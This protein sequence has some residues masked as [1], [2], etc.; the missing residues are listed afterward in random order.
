LVP[1]RQALG[2]S[3]NERPRSKHQRP[4]DLQLECV[5]NIDLHILEPELRDDFINKMETNVLM[6][7][8]FENDTNEYDKIHRSEIRKPDVAHDVP[9]YLK[10][11]PDDAH[12]SKAEEAF[13]LSHE[14]WRNRVQT[15]RLIRG[16]LDNNPLPWGYFGYRLPALDMFFPF[17]FLTRR[18]RLT[19]S[20]DSKEEKRYQPLE[21]DTFCSPA[22]KCYSDGYTKII[23]TF[24]HCLNGY[25]QRR[26]N[27]THSTLSL[28]CF[29]LT[30]KGEQRGYVCDYYCRDAY[31]FQLQEDLRN[32]LR[33]R[34]EKQAASSS[35][36]TS[37]SKSFS[38]D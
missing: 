2:Y 13:R 36:P 28:E 32:E 14:A 23:P 26:F 22:C 33:L 1:L 27:L 18:N 11:L 29:R 30:Y 7:R 3:L 34:Q 9:Y 12:C 4:Y 19:T 17:A 16:K 37:P 10:N 31:L 21:F 25:C 6:T 24:E 38:S 5:S 8:Q 15:Y 20:M 35:V